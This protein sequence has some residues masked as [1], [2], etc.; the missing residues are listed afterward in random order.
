MSDSPS[1]SL[2]PAG[3][4]VPDIFRQRLGSRA[5]RQ[6]VMEA[7]GHLLLVLHAPPQPDEDNRT[8]RIFWRSPDGKWQPTG[9]RSSATALDELLAEYKQALD[10]LDS[11]E[12]LAKNARDYFEVLRQL[13]PL[14]R[15]LANVYNV[16]QEARQA[17]QEA[18]ELI[19]ARDTAYA[20]SRRA[21]LLHKESQHGLDFE[22]AR[23]AERQAESSHKMAESA[24]RLNIL[25]AFFFP[26]ATIAGIFGMNLSHG[27][28]G[29][30][31]AEAP[32]PL[33]SV[34]A[35]ALV[36]GS[37]L[38]LFVTLPIHKRRE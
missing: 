2:I 12:D 8:A 14:V 20:L 30:N 34:V 24:H 36:L 19:H 13:N 29:W 11:A 37:V 33:I 21:E 1:N 38:T 15:T 31:A 18:R 9:L 4:K 35:I 27:L 28:E 17:C 16:L 32:W 3:W 10:Q 7:E 22:V 23:Q 5:G 26:L 25:V 6:R